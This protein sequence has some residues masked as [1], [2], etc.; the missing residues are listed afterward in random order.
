MRSSIVEVIEE[1]RREVKARLVVHDVPDHEI[2]IRVLLGAI[3]AERD[4]ARRALDQHAAAKERDLARRRRA[5]R[6]ASR[7][8]GCG[9]SVARA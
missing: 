8:V 1:V 2:A 6:C 4:A 5:C 9:T 7:V 3:A